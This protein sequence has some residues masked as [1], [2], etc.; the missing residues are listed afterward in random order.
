MSK[1]KIIGNDFKIKFD[2]QQHQVDANV[3]V[4]SLIHTTTIVQEVNKYLNSGKKIEIKVK[5]LE[6][7][8]FLCHIELVETTIDSLKNLLTKDNIEVGAAIVTTVVGI[9]ELKKFLKGKKA[10]EVQKQGDRTKII[11]KD[12]N[13][14]IIENA[15]FNIYEHSPVVKDALAQNFDALNNDPAITGFE[16]TDKNENALVR[17]D[18]SEFVELSQKSE[19]VEEGERKI[20]EA[21]TVNVV[22]VS[23]EESLKWDFYYR[24]I[25]ISAKIADPSFYELIDKGEAFAKGDV[26][27]V[28]LQIHQKFDESVNT[29]VTKSYTVNKIVRHLSRNEQQKINFKPEE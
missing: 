24:G 11:N 23:F 17:V 7:G 16:I 14:L 20:V 13:V 27:E 12:G 3:L 1:A 9:I 29:F 18:K 21:A 25:K 4:S 15:T 8:S 6:K 10:K 5:A 19:E 28:E 26:L 2:G 22:R